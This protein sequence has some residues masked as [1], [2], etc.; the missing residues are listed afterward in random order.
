[1]KRINV[2]GTSGSGKSY[3][4]RK[5]AKKLNYPYYEMDALF[6]KSNWRETEDEEFCPL[7][8]SKLSASVWVLDGNYNRTLQI[9]WKQADTVIWL[10]YSFSRVL[11]QGIKRTLYRCFTKKEL[12]SGT[13]NIESFGKSFF[14]RDSI[15]IWMLKSYRRNRIRYNKI[16]NSKAYNHIYFIRLTSPKVAKQ[17]LQNIKLKE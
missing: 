8:K 11:F 12:W 6:W 2:I 4:S 10:D 1:M 9:K 14:S 3:F 13:G 17:F 5:L 15:I 16:Y 7:L